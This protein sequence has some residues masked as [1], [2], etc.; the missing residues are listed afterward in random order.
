M[1]PGRKRTV[2]GNNIL[3]PVFVKVQAE[4]CVRREGEGLQK[5]PEIFQPMQGGRIGG[6]MRRR[7]PCR[8]KKCLFC[9]VL[10][11]IKKDI[12]DYTY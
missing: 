1:V 8:R 5:F 11:G 9:L 7:P 10:N 3:L 6:R 2:M 12:A 4:K